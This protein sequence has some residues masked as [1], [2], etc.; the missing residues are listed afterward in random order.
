[1]SAAELVWLY[2]ID[3][4]E[5]LVQERRPQVRRYLTQVGDIERLRSYDVSQ[6][7]REHDG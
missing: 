1:M 2:H 3:T 7:S 6:M 5:Y 4:Y